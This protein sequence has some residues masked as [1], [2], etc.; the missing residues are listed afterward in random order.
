MRIVIASA[1][2]KFN[3]VTRLWE[4]IRYLTSQ[5]HEWHVVGSGKAFEAVEKQY[6]DSFGVNYPRDAETEA[7]REQLLW[8]YNSDLEAKLQRFRPHVMLLDGE[9]F[10][11]QVAQ[12]LKIPILSIDPQHLFHFARF[13]ITIPPT[14][15][16]QL[17]EVKESVK[18]IPYRASHYLMPNFI[19]A[20][21]RSKRAMLT[22]PVL[23]QDTLNSEPTRGD[24]MLAFAWPSLQEDLALFS[25]VEQPVL[26]HIP[27][28]KQR[29][30]RERVLFEREV[31][32]SE[33]QLLRRRKER[34]PQELAPAELDLQ[35]PPSTRHVTYKIAGHESW[36]KD[37]VDARAVLIDGNPVTIAEAI[38]LKKPMLVIPKPDDFPQW[39]FGQY[40]EHMGLGEYHPHLT[41]AAL[42]G[43]L[44][45]QDRY[46]DK[47]T[48][49]QSQSPTFFE[50]LDQ[51]LPQFQ[52]PHQR[53]PHRTP[54]QR[55]S[56]AG[57]RPSTDESNE[58]E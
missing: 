42:E 21:I 33:G 53:K 14:Q 23:P 13:D 12:K 47:L 55:K 15:F 37:L 11:S 30:K 7:E 48:S 52:T 25:L 24:K 27:L 58:P 40:V 17:M 26:A 29:Q 1:L 9:Y 38:A 8:Q 6:P 41:R 18:Q 19:Q 45:R 20:P 10:A 5:S 4:T 39:C 44:N 31:S 49:Y 50:G 3:S 36:S 46:L 22:Q 28:R 56:V 34:L 2:D 32:G 16:A 54:L 51:A 57:N 43:F 35:L